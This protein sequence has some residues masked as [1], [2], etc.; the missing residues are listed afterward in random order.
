MEDEM[1]SDD[2]KYVDEYEIIADFMA[3]KT[4]FVVAEETTT[5]VSNYGYFT[6]YKNNADDMAW[7]CLVVGRKEELPINQKMQVANIFGILKQANGN[8]KIMVGL[9]EGHHRGLVS[10]QIAGF[11]AYYRALKKGKSV[12]FEPISDGR[13]VE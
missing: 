8:N 3:G 2:A 9:S 12:T 7:D 4:V 1:L 5:F 11:A 10:P 6:D 13:Y